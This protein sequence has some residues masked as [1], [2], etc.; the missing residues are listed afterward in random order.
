MKKIKFT[1]N[2][3]LISKTDIEKEN[4]EELI[5]NGFH[6]N[7]E[8]FKQVLALTSPKIIL[9]SNDKGFKD[10]IDLGI[11]LEILSISS[12]II[13]EKNWFYLSYFISLIRTKRLQLTFI[14]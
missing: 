14:L 6:L 7:E 13:F 5:K 1:P 9:E 11:E 4:V 8:N 10:E 2:E 3:T 12:K